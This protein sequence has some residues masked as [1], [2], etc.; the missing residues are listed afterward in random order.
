MTRAETFHATPALY[1]SERMFV[2]LK[3][4]RCA[5]EDAAFELDAARMLLPDVEQMLDELGRARRLI[6]GMVGQLARRKG[7]VKAVARTLHV[8]TGEVRSA[9]DAAEMV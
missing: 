5:L 4:A 8:A 9:M 6:D 2:S 3:D 7:D 1:R